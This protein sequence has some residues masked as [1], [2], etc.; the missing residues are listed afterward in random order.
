MRFRG[1]VALLALA[2]VPLAPPSAAATGGPVV[3]TDAGLVRGTVEDGLRRFEGVPFAA[4]PVGE[5]RW[6]APRPV[7]PWHG[8]RD[9]TSPRSQCAQL[10][11]PYGGQTTYVEDC[12]YLNV[13]TPARRAGAR[14]PVMV[15]VHGGSNVTGSGSAYDAAKLAADGD[16]V[17]VTVNYRLGPLGW[18]A[19]PS[20]EADEPGVQAGNYGLL[21]QQA[22]L[23]WVRRNAAAFGGD[24]GNVTLFGESAGATDTCA[25]LVSPATRG[26][27]HRAVMQSYSCAA[28]TRSPEPAEAQADAFATALGCADSACLRALPVR[29][30]LERFAA[31]QGQAGPIA[32][33][34]RI[35]PRQP[36]DAIARG[37]FNRM[38]V[39]HG[40]T[41][42][43]MRLFVAL[44]LPTEITV[45]RYEAMIAATYGE[46]AAEVLA[47]YPATAYPTPRIALAT[48]QS[49][50]GTALSTCDHLTAY[51][52][53][54]ARVPVYAYQFAD[55]QAPPLI[56]VPDF[57]E[58]AEHGTELTYLWPGLLGELTPAQ[59]ELSDTMVRHW[60]SFAHKGRPGGDWPRFRTSADVLSLAPG[61]VGP[62]DVAAASNCAFWRG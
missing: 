38:P 33:G 62:V 51:E 10:A 14:L 17:V 50:A 4:P 18:L 39:M 21:D 25:N 53:L 26:L 12:L 44:T 15:W 45:A 31:A 57:D 3:R 28:P 36:A 2:V 56:D 41:L 48:V 37:A 47:R 32:G 8:V 61:A 1:L 59:E 13:T 30:L 52:L 5:L 58:G 24:A 42:D 22:A 20:F 29:T 16:V 60:T 34:D 55:R 27:F 11:P 19:H 49:D 43:E 35:L 23:R 9:A 40:N 46:R 7:R 54:A 6:R